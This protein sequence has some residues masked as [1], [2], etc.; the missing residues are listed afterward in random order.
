MLLLFITI[1][2]KAIRGKNGR[3]VIWTVVF[4]ESARRGQS[5][6]YLRCSLE[7]R[8]LQHTAENRNEALFWSQFCRPS[9]P[10]NFNAMLCCSPRCSGGTHYCSG[11]V[12]NPRG[13]ASFYSTPP[14]ELLAGILSVTSPITSFQTRGG[15]TSL[16]N[17]AR[18]AIHTT[19]SR[20]LY[21]DPQNCEDCFC[22]HLQTKHHAQCSPIFL[23]AISKAIHQHLPACF[24]F[25]LAPFLSAGAWCFG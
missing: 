18:L 19:K 20:N 16:T 3:A 23:W 14:P 17:K 6:V 1:E 24:H 8:S 12:G 4:D 10:R 9:L 25:S 15:T 5:S 22:C 13:P 7:P 2:M 11:Q 21:E